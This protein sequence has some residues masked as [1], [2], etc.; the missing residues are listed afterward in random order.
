MFKTI[1]KARSGWACLFLVV[2]VAAL[3]DPHATILSPAVPPP[4]AAREFSEDIH[5]V[6]IADPY[7]WLEDQKSPETRAWID[8][9]IA[10]TRSI[11]AKIPGREELKQRLS[12]LSRV[13]SMRTPGVIKNR[14][15]FAKRPAGQDQ[16]ILYMREGLQGKDQVLVDPLPLS[17]D[18]TI[19]A[20]FGS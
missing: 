8:G 18:H 5:G 16:Y 1:F 15:F 19:S 9:Q 14:Y 11:L 10:Y 17:S 6:K 7:R 13:D 3:Q 20:S 2:S 4:T 12:A